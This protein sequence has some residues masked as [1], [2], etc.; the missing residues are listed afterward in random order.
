MIDLPLN[1]K[2]NLTF[3]SVDACF[4][5]MEKFFTNDELESI[6]IYFLDTSFI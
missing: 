3:K 4:E 5:Y 2:K 1:K 6:R